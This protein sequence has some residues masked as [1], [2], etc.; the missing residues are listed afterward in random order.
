[1]VTMG[2]AV[3]T[4]EAAVY[5]KHPISGK[6]VSCFHFGG[7]A[8]EAKHILACIWHTQN[9]LVH[10]TIRLLGWVYS[11]PPMTQAH[12]VQNFSSSRELPGVSGNT[13]A[14]LK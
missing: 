13:P 2:G 9:P 12:C 11:Q 4:T 10:R 8:I 3:V 14:S 1:M 5:R 6:V 7:W